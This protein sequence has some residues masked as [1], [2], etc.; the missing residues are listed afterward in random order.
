MGRPDLFEF[1][2]KVYCKG[3]KPR[4]LK[5]VIASF[6]EKEVQCCTLN[7]G[8]W[9]RIYFCAGLPC[10][11]HVHIQSTTYIKRL[12]HPRLNTD[13]RVHIYTTY[14]QPLCSNTHQS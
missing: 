11:V 9:Y 7:T 10:I 6:P 5:P 12:K 1:S 4:R 3:S 2:A 8:I 13:G 14:R